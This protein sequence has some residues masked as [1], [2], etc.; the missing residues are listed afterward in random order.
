ML[1]W[2]PRLV[3]LVFAVIAIAALAARLSLGGT[4]TGTFG[5]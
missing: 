1:E 2:N 5:W 4:G 3:T